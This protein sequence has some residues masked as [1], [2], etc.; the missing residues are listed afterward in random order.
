MKLCKVVLVSNFVW[1]WFSDIDFSF[2]EDYDADPVKFARMYLIYMNDLLIFALYWNF[3]VCVSASLDWDKKADSSVI[4]LP[5]S[6]LLFWVA[7]PSGVKGK[8]HWFPCN[9]FKL[10]ERMAGL[11]CFVKYE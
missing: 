9:L 1:W 7:P 8:R 2:S 6:V 4:L 5:L 11:F 3:G 10:E